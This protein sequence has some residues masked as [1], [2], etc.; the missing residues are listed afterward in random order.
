MADSRGAISLRINLDVS[1]QGLITDLHKAFQVAQKDAESSASK[2]EQSF[3]SASGKVTESAQRMST[4]L[5]SVGQQGLVTKESIGGLWTP[6]QLDL[7]P[8]RSEL[9]QVRFDLVRAFQVP[10]SMEALAVDLGTV[11]A[12]ASTQAAVAANEIQTSLGA[13]EFNTVAANLQA[14]FVETEAFAASLA[15]NLGNV[16]N[17]TGPEI[18]SDVDPTDEA[19]ARFERMRDA[20]RAIAANLPDGFR[21]AGEEILGAL[22]GV[23]DELP[24]IFDRSNIELS[25]RIRDLAGRL[26]REL[27]G[28]GAELANELDPRPY[29]EKKFDA[30]QAELARIARSL[31]TE[32]RGA[33]VA[34]S[35]AL[36]EAARKIPPPMA[37]AVAKV[38]DDLDGVPKAARQ[39]ATATESAFARAA[40]DI[41][42]QFNG[43]VSSITSKF[44]GLKRSLGNI[45]QIA[46]GNVVADAA[47]RA[48]SG[49]SGFLSESVQSSIDL[50]AFQKRAEN[51]F[52]AAAG[53]V[54]NFA[55]TTATSLGLSEKQSLGLLGAFGN[56]FTQYGLKVDDAAQRSINFTKAAGNLAALNNLDPNQVGEA[57][58]A[59]VR[60]EYDSLQRALPKITQNR[61]N[62]EA[63]S[64]AH[65]K[66][67]KDLSDLEK[68][69]GLYSVVM[70]DSA[71]ADGYFAKNVNV[72]AIALQA[73]R[74][75]LEDLQS[76]I[77]TKLIP[78]QVQWAKIQL[79][80]WT[81]VADKVVPIVER[82][83][84]ALGDRLAPAF[85]AAKAAAQDFWSGLTQGSGVDAGLFERLGGAVRDFFATLTTGQTGSSVSTVELIALDIRQ[86]VEFLQRNEP[87]IAGFF[88]A[89]AG[90][91]GT[92][93]GFAAQ[94]PVLTIAIL[95]GVQ[96][97]SFLAP[98]FSTLGSV[99]GAIGPVIA[100]V[101]AAFA[102]GGLAGVLAL[103]AN[104]VGL[105]V[106][107]I[108][109]LA[110]AVVYA[111]KSSEKFRDAVATLW[112]VIK[113]GAGAA[114]G[115]VKKIDFSP[116]MPVLDA[117]VDALTAVVEVLTV[118][119]ALIIVVFKALGPSLL[120]FVNLVVAGIAN[121]LQGALQIIS[122]II[123]IIV[124]LVTGDWSK[125]WEGIK[126]VV[127]GVMNIIGGLV[128]LAWAGIISGFLGAMGI[129]RVFVGDRF[130][131]IISFIGELPTR[132]AGIAAG[133][134]DSLKDG[135][136]PVINFII[137]QL[138]GL[139][140]A[141][142]V[143]NPFADIPKI[144]RM[145]TGAK[146]AAVQRPV[147]RAATGD[148]AFGRQLRV[149]GD[150]PGARRDPE[151]VAP[152]SY[153][154]AAV[155]A[156]IAAAMAGQDSGRPGTTFQIGQVV[157]PEGRDVWQELA[158]TER[159]YA[160]V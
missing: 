81:F 3:R 146:A 63:L 143:I 80:F 147:K 59:G 69:Q 121:V 76:R 132:V 115:F 157:V 44:S 98:V 144:P 111:W 122:G 42:D 87:A 41:P 36:T 48:T 51:V 131:D 112:G 145:G 30:L 134:W 72:A 117:L 118:G 10:P 107:A 70:K 19:T 151:I 154:R 152:Q 127:A 99:I 90:G 47:S 71:Y 22:G 18:A 104:P 142:N 8:V 5:Q 34:L 27:V 53:S 52:G 12:Q 60:G 93:V 106:V 57:L 23:S 68:L 159:I 32:F 82:W 94:F 85:Q 86:F 33:A 97:V 75:Q 74:A 153:I 124:G 95:A 4:A 148:V 96:A 14:A 119:V 2:V 140:G 64:L 126:N 45:L 28:V 89:V 58:Q 21:L 137:D 136:A 91:I 116:V 92:V 100:A 56:Q 123:K 103:V 102:E 158:M 83:A 113:I 130:G 20:V 129:L 150:N 16:F 35:Q 155:E 108:V 9:E 141:L 128:Q 17:G 25:N 39:A 7:T 11:F 38:E 79:G 6:P 61:I 31:P 49:I 1:P 78:L 15:T 37:D 54:Q 43:V 105:A 24:A 67:A 26:P 125:A 149:I 84:P 77:G 138:N 55:K 160:Q 114:A 66:R 88:A 46:V 156:G 40:R 13:L 50:G 109:A 135:L 29:T 65:K 110:A 101:T 133:M 73:Q 62:E 139:V 120:A